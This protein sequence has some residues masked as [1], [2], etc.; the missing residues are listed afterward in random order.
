MHERLSD[1]KYILRIVST[2]DSEDRQR[3]EELICKKLAMNNRNN[4]NVKCTVIPIDHYIFEEDKGYC[5]SISKCYML[6]NSKN[7]EPLSH[8]LARGYYNRSLQKN[9]TEDTVY[10]GLLN[11]IEGVALLKY[12]NHPHR[13]INCDTVY[14]Y[15]DNNTFVLGD[16]WISPLTDFHEQYHAPEKLKQMRNQVEKHDPYLAD[17]FS[18]GMVGLKMLGHAN[19]PEHYSLN[20]TVNL[21]GLVKLTESIKHS[22]LRS[23]ILKLLS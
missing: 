21:Q 8:H 2:N 18:I 19:L 16:P 1:N 12:Y 4:Q 11:L 10:R 13:H 9:I 20:K 23:L 17:L 5:N 7:S 14:Y 15:K 22:N 6:F 3:M